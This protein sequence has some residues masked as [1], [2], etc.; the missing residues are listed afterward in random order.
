M[1]VVFLDYPQ[2]ICDPRQGA[3]CFQ[4]INPYRFILNHDLIEVPKGFWTDWASVGLAASI[5]SPIAPAIC[6]PALGH[7]FLYFCGYADSQ[8][9]CDEFISEGMRVE[10]A[11]WWK[12]AIVFLGLT[13][14]GRF[15]WDRYRREN[16]KY[17]QTVSLNS[18]K[19][20][21]PMRLLTIE[22][23]DKNR[24]GLS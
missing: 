10:G 1:K 20:G 13:I 3:K 15:T 8:R 5:I 23:W 16:T 6:R 14:G 21:E 7:D 9:V 22:N 11:P 19:E 4:L 17:H 24:D 18:L 12:R 2:T